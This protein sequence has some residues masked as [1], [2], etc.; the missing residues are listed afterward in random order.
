[1]SDKEEKDS[2][3]HV[4]TLRAYHEVCVQRRRLGEAPLTFQDFA[5][6]CQLSMREV[7]RA[8]ESLVQ[9]NEKKLWFEDEQVARLQE[10]RERKA[11]IQD[12]KERM[13]E[14][15]ERL[16]VFTVYPRADNAQ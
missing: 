9:E 12:L 4:G 7:L 10:A 6:N 13:R 15:E 14:L 3:Q 16:T 11:E 1:M 5:M 8:V 2:K